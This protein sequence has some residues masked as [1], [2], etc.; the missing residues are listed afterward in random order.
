MGEIP[1]IHPDEDLRS[2]LSLLLSSGSDYLRVE[3]DSGTEQGLI[4][5]EDLKEMLSS[6]QLIE[7]KK[8]DE[9]SD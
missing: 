7:K 4:S 1:T 3:D 8:C 5:M 6:N 2:A 9:I